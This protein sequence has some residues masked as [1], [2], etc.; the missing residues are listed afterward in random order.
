MSA[1]ANRHAFGQPSSTSRSSPPRRSSPKLPQSAEAR[2][3]LGLGVPVASSRL[4]P[5]DEETTQYVPEAMPGVSLSALLARCAHPSEPDGVTARMK[6]AEANVTSTS[7]IRPRGS[8]HTVPHFPEESAPEIQMTAESNLHQV[9]ADRITDALVI[10][11]QRDAYLHVGASSRPPALVSP[12]PPR[13]RRSFG[14]KVL[15]VTIAIAVALL[16]ATEL[17]A[18]GKVPWLDPRPLLTKGLRLAK[19]KIP[20]DRLPGIHRR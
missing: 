10:D 2:T 9:E 6:V 8:F 19:D 4:D 7:G 16:A 1:P 12:S 20:W 13:P 11:P 5:L 15:F 18:A 14:A 3:V 17:A